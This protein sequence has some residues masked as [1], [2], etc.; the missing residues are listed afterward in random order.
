[1]GAQYG[2]L[3]G[4]LDKMIAELKRI[5]ANTSKCC[6]LTPSVGTSENTPADVKYLKVTKTNGTGTVTITFPDATVQTLTASGEV[7]EIPYTG[8]K[9]P[10]VVIESADGGTWSWLTLN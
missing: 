7:F 6:N 3:R 1:M 5:S 10:S 4:P 9:Y 8:G 2:D